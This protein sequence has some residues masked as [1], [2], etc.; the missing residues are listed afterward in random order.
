MDFVSPECTDKLIV[1]LATVSQLYS[2]TDGHCFL[3]PSVAEKD[4]RGYR[5]PQWMRLTN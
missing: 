4:L 1:S 3:V 2:G 5:L